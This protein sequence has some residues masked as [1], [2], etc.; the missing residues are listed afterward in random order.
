MV[1]ISND[2]R[3]LMACNHAFLMLTGYSRTDI[4]ILNPAA[5]FPGDE[6]TASLSS[7]LKLAEQPGRRLPK[8][9]LVVR[10]GSTSQVEINTLPVNSSVGAQVFTIQV[11]GYAKRRQ[12]RQTAESERLSALNDISRLLVRSETGSLPTFL[13]ISRQALCASHL[14]I[15]RVSPNSPEYAL[16]GELPPGFPATLPTSDLTQTGKWTIGQRSSHAL[17]KAAKAAGY[18]AVRSVALGTQKAWIGIL[19]AVWENKDSLTEDVDPLLAIIGNLCHATIQVGLQQAILAE[20]GR[21]LSNLEGELRVQAAMVSEA[22]LVLDDDLRLVR[23]NSAAAQMLGY[24][25]HELRGLPVQDV[26]VGPEDPLPTLLDTLGHQRESERL[27]L[28]IHRRDGSPFPAQLR[29]TPMSG[30]GPG[31]LLVALSDQSE[32]QA[33]EDQTEILAQRALLGEVTA[34]FAHEVRNPINNISTGVQLVSSRLGEDHKLHAALATVQKECIRLD[35]LM[36]DVLFFARPLELKIEPA[37]LHEMLEKLIV[38]WRPRFERNNVTCHLDLQ[39]NTPEALLDPRT[40]EQVVVNLITNALDVMPNGGALSF[41]LAAIDTLQGEMIELKVADTGPGM[42]PEVLARIFDPFYTTKKEGTGLGLA[43]TK[44][45][46][47]AHKGAIMAETF[48]DAGT[49]FSV[50]VPSIHAI[51]AESHR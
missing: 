20:M 46:L 5:L 31:K 33:I 42:P 24:R 26:L 25:Q 50:R 9:P 18:Q 23:A 41:S 7:I 28:T 36:S 13:E 6:A 10:D 19:V 35:Q 17:H 4:E 27:F 40:F 38:R 16:D 15:Y 22:L 1:V 30:S 34:I 39:P 2:G 48:P 45:I 32:R 47:T 3:Q 11:A 44:R 21:S 37:N 51:G 43:I 29:V 49:V 8:I 14:G 12:E